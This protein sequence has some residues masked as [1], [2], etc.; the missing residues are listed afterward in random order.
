MTRLSHSNRCL[1]IGEVTLG[2][3]VVQARSPSTRYMADV[4]QRLVHDTWGE[5]V[6]CN[7]DSVLARREGAAFKPDTPA[8]A[9]AEGFVFCE[10]CV[11][12]AP[13]GGYG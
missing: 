9:Q 7:L 1:R 4:R 12:R 2:I 13:I 6:S 11:R 5:K 3:A 8:Q 10:H